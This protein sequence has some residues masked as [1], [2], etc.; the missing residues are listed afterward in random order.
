M[1]TAF[2]MYAAVPHTVCVQV[3]WVQIP[4]HQEAAPW[5]EQPTE[6]TGSPEDT[7]TRLASGGD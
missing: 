7:P 1:V 4:R 2:E 3:L 6:P 5:L